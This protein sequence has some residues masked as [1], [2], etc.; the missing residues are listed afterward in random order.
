M[1]VVEFSH[2]CRQLKVSQR[3]DGDI[4]SRLNSNSEAAKRDVYMATGVSCL[5]TQVHA[6]I[7]VL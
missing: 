2:P 5:A 4:V 7:L 6:L 3:A 1:I